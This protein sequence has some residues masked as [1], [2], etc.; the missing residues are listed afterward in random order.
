M[1]ARRRPLL[2][3]NT[4]ADGFSK[5]PLSSSESHLDLQILWAPWF[6]SN[7]ADNSIHNHTCS[8]FR[9]RDNILPFPFF[10]CFLKLPPFSL[11]KRASFYPPPP[12]EQM[13]FPL[14]FFYSRLRTRQE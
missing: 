13:A 8:P 2:R 1:P 10:R 14:R 6:G 3:E 5:F 7:I 4:D 11:L 9:E 12:F